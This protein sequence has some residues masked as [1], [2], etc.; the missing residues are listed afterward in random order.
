MNKLVA[1]LLSVAWLACAADEKITHAF[2]P[3]PLSELDRAAKARVRSTARVPLAESGDANYVRALS[4]TPAAVDS[5]KKLVNAALFTGGLDPEV[6]EA[7]GLRISQLLRAPYVSAHMVHLLRGSARGKSLLD[8]L[9]SDRL[10]SLSPADRLA[11]SYAEWLTQDVRG[12]SNA[13]FALVRQHYNDSQLVELTTTTCFFAYMTR[14]SEALNL[15]VEEAILSAPASPPAASNAAPIARV[16]LI[17]DAEIA[18]IEQ[19]KASSMTQ[20]VKNSLGLNLANSMR[21]MYLAPEVAQAWFQYLSSTRQ[22]DKVSREIKLQVSFAVSTAN[23]CRYCT[24][25]QVLGLKRL[26]VS[27]AKLMQMRK[28]DTALTPEELTAV[29]F[30]RKLTAEP[31]TVADSDYAGLEKTFGNQGALEV[32]M[33]ACNFSYMNHFTDGLRLPSEDVA[34]KTY[35]EVYG[36]EFSR[37]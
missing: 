2:K 7:M 13:D 12:V 3:I 15:P 34:V 27:T 22:Y 5:M 28:D 16:S 33:Q 20:D 32:L 14:F 11:I 29:Q 36:S 30:A 18:A 35:L 6:K 1:L 31:W 26:G 37:R 25:H 4:L 21:A 9:Y 19:T 10:R 24:L 17:S 8:A 23:N